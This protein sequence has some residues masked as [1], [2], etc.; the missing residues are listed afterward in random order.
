MEGLG[1]NQYMSMPN[2][3]YPGNSMGY[4]NPYPLYP[5]SYAPFPQQPQIIMMPPY[6][7]Q[8]QTPA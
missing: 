4:Q 3:S 2:F 6:P 7:Q 1:I 5:Q 8:S